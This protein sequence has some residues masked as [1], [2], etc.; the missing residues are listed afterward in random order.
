MLPGTEYRAAARFV[1]DSGGAATADDAFAVSTVPCPHAERCAL[2]PMCPAE[3]YAVYQ[4]RFGLD[5][6]EPVSPR[7]LYALRKG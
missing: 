4:Q 7:A 6:Y 1:H 3:H 5:E 2:A